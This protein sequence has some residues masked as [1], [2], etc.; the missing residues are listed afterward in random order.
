MTSIVLLASAASVFV[1]TV[2]GA[3][4][5]TSK[6]AAQ[7]FKSA[8][9]NSRAATSF[10]VSGSV[11][12]PKM[13]LT[14]NLSL[15]ASGMSEGTLTINGGHIEIRE[16]GKTGYFNA[17]K[18]FWTTNGDAATAQLFAG[19]WIYAPITNSLFSS[20]RSFL[21]PRTFI[22]SF[23][24]TDQGP[25]AKTGNSV[26]NGKRVVGV[27]ADGP[28]T[29]Y[30]AASGTHFIVKVQGSNSGSTASLTFGSYNVAVHPV[31]PAGGVS[32]QS[33]EN[34]Q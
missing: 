1:P 15:S 6:S 21:S 12:Q 28:G 3:D 30:V 10:S 29:M 11:D 8:V 20:L 17:D 5:F 2:A 24:G 4:G 14:L 32:L 7:I 9:A 26:V 18:A 34:A 19:K 16:I 33:L 23:F 25:Y 13:N 27:M 31:K 22:Q